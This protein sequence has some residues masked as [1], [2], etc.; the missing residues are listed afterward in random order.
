MLNI[1]PQCTVQQA[2]KHLTCVGHRKTIP[3]LRKG[4]V[5]GTSWFPC[6]CLTNYKGDINKS[7]KAHIGQLYIFLYI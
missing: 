2:G 7:V 4:I 3:E 5:Q 6:Y 1:L